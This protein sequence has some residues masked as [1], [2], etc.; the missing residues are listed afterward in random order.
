M[1]TNFQESATN[2]P[3]MREQSPGSQSVSL[4]S[5]YNIWTDNLGAGLQITSGGYIIEL[6][7]F[8]LQ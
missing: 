4:F 7:G 6:S 5:A 3:L 2:L 8:N 1:C